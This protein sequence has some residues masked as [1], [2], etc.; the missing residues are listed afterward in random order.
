MD[1]GRCRAKSAD[2]EPCVRAAF[3]DDPPGEFVAMGWNVTAGWHV[4]AAGRR[5]PVDGAAVREAP[6]APPFE[7][8]HGSPERSIVPPSAAPDADAG[9][10][11][12]TD[13]PS[14][15]CGAAGAAPVSAVIA[16]AIPAPTVVQVRPG[17]VRILAPQGQGRK[18]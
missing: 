13:H 14:D 15:P 18:A 12:R 8:P 2:G 6:G 7:A 5:F 17:I 1:F 10:R 4:T 16:Q 3:H 11:P 9:A